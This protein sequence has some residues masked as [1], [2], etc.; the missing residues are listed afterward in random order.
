MFAHT[1]F[2]KPLLP[3]LNISLTGPAKWLWTG[4]DSR[5]TSY[6]VLLP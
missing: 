4:Y 2:P 6:R 3:V 1:Y 5:D